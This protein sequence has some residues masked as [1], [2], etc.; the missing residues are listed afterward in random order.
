MWP[1]LIGLVSAIY[2]VLSLRAFS[3]RRASFTQFLSAHAALTLTRYLRLAAL[4]IALNLP[5]PASPP[6]RAPSAR[7]S[8]PSS[9]RA[10]RPPPA[11]LCSFG[12]FGFVVEVRR[13]YT[14][15]DARIM[16]GFWRAAGRVG[17]Q[18]R[19]NGFFAAASK[20]KTKG[21][22]YT[23]PKPP[24]K[25]TVS[26]PRYAQS[27][28][29][30]FTAS[31]AGSEFGTD[32]D[33]EVELKRCP[34]ASSSFHSLGV[35]SRFVKKLEGPPSASTHEHPYP[36]TPDYAPDSPTTTASDSPAS[37]DFVLPL[38]VA[39]HARAY[40]ADHGVDGEYDADWEPQWFP[41]LNAHSISM[42]VFPTPPHA[43]TGAGRGRALV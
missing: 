7:P 34:L 37:P 12:F 13:N 38:H 19:A 20:E 16:P 14:F 26:L 6:S 35:P 1:P 30:S 27:G 31:F 25:H 32:V 22:G 9:S 24:A 11:R 10:G 3:A 8:S 15:L 36:T 21:V 29:G 40:P 42:D 28:T 33:M 41:A 5:P 18:R 2:Y 43:D 17:I 23:Q 39:W 4:T